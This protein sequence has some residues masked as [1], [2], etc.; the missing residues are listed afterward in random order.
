MTSRMKGAGFTVKDAGRGVAKLRDPRGG[1][2]GGALL[3]VLAQEG[4]PPLHPR[5]GHQAR[6]QV[7]GGCAGRRWYATGEDEVHRETSGHAVYETAEPK[8]RVGANVSH[9]RRHEL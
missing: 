3:T 2:R 1:V 5:V 9:Q 8:R 7:G 4:V 6:K